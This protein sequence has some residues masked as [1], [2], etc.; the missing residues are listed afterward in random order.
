MEKHDDALNYTW[1]A[2]RY[3][4]N[5]NHDKFLERDKPTWGFDGSS[6]RF[7]PRDLKHKRESEHPSPFNY[8]KLD[9]INYRGNKFTEHKQ[10]LLPRPP[11]IRP[12]VSEY[13]P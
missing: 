12:M 4:P 10:H 5:K 1:Q 11:K 8:A 6:P 13:I 7:S 3:S 2:N 9:L